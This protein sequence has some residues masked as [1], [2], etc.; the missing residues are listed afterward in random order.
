MTDLDAAV[1]HLRRGDWEAAH[2]IVQEDD[3]ALSCW[4]HGIV[5]LLEGD[6]GNAG[7]WYRRAGR[8]LPP[9]GPD[10]SAVELQALAAA[11]A[12]GGAE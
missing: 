2:R 3:S 1:E 4:A 8:V 12:Q 10:R 7:Y 5:H 9:P 11:V 6:E